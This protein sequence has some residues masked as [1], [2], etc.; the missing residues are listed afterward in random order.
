VA[1]P[2]VAGVALWRA[3]S[4]GREVDYLVVP[5]NVGDDDLLADLVSLLV[6]SQG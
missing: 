5:G 3:E 6:G 2:V 1:G 4:R